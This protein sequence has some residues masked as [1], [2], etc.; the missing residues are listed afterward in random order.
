MQ[1]QHTIICKGEPHM[2]AKRFSIS[3]KK[4]RVEMNS[5][6]HNNQAMAYLCLCS[7]EMM[8]A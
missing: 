6:Q 7:F 8:I 2:H 1:I 5:Y 3:S 4:H